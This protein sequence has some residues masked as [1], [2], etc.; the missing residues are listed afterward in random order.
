MNGFTKMP[1]DDSVEQAQRHAAGWA[2]RV[3]ADWNAGRADAAITKLV[4]AIAHLRKDS[5][6]PV[7]IAQVVAEVLDERAANSARGI[8]AP[9]LTPYREAERALLGQRWTAGEAASLIELIKIGAA[10]PP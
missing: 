8:A 7:A 1:A 2:E 9:K 10:V 5:H 3:L 4:V 6:P